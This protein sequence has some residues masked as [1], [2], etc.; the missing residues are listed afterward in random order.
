MWRQG[1]TQ[2]VANTYVRKRALRNKQEFGQAMV[3]YIVVTLM[4]VVYFTGIR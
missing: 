2:V 3:E 1:K 4:V